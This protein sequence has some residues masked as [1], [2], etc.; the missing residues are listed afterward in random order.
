MA[1]K[2]KIDYAQAG[3]LAVCLIVIVVLWD[4]WAVYPLR[5]LVVFFH[6]LSHGIAAVVT[7]GSI[8][9]IQMNAQEGGLCITRGGNRFLTLS[10]GYLGSL[11]WGGAI[12]L[13]ATRTKGSQI[14]LELLGGLLIVVTLIWVRPLIGFGVGFGLATGLVLIAL[15]NFLKPMA[16]EL[17]LIVIGLTS[18][19]YAVLDIKSDILDRPHAVS[20]AVLLADVTGVPALVWGVLWLGVSIVLAVRFILIA[21]R[22]D[23]ASQTD[24]TSAPT[25]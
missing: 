25:P 4:T 12:L 20:D 15:A 24:A 7:G 22:H 21:S 17:I 16:T 1:A 13:F 8:V 23:T 6:E 11:L 2:G 10:A 18:C 19:L 9:E 14:V 3:G 5:L